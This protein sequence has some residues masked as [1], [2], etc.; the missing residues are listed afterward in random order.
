MGWRYV[1]STQIGEP[2]E[3]EYNTSTKMWVSSCN[4]SVSAGVNNLNTWLQ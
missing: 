2:T 4:W 1:K 3:P